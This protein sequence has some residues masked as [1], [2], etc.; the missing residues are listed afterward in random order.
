MPAIKPV[1]KSRINAF[2]VIFE[3]A[4]S[5]VP[6]NPHLNITDIITN[7]RYAIATHIEIS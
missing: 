1:I 5:D 7:L 3:I 4:I 6:A 2:G